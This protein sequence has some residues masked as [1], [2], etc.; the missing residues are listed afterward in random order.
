MTEAIAE[1]NNVFTSR[2][3]AKDYLQP[4]AQKYGFSLCVRGESIKCTRAGAP[5]T[6]QDDP[7]TEQRDRGSQKCGCPF[8]LYVRIFWLGSYLLCL[9]NFLIL[10]CSIKSMAVF[11]LPMLS[12]SALCILRSLVKRGRTTKYRKHRESGIMGTVA[13]HVQHRY[14]VRRR[15]GGTTHSSPAS[16]GNTWPR[17][18]QRTRQRSLS[19]MLFPAYIVMLSLYL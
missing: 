2:V 4:I 9:L 3:D 19:S 14:A 7:L 15:R 16:N 5:D 8:S 1:R 17:S 12:G 6:K 10:E 18:L 11:R 13:S